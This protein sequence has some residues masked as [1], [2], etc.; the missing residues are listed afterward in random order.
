MWWNQRLKWPNCGLEAHLQLIAS[1][2]SPPENRPLDP[3]ERGASFPP[4]ELVVLGTLR[5][6]LG[7]HRRCPVD[8]DKKRLGGAYRSR[9]PSLSSGEKREPFFEAWIILV[10]PPKKKVGN[11]IGATEQLSPP[12]TKKSWKRIG[13]IHVATGSPGESEPKTDASTLAPP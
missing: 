1:T 9:H 2:I 13:G 4:A 11:R 8:W 12:P 5:G 3:L 6:E 7:I 10:G